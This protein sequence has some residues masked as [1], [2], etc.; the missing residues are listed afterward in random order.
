MRLFFGCFLM[1][2]L[3]SFSI[4][5][6]SNIEGLVIKFNKV[7]ED[8]VIPGVPNGP[9]GASPIVAGEGMKFVKLKITLENKGNKNCTFN[10]DDIYISTEQDSLYRI[11]IF[12]KYFPKYFISSDAKIKPQKE[13]TRSIFFEFPDKMTPKEL[14]IED[15][16][17]K[18]V[19]EKKD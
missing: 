8:Y 5:Q 13:I 2:F 18:I 11:Y 3:V 6:E 17:Y 10:F 9:Y 12:P 19:E 16:R 7:S 14:F 15:K 4:N 1:F